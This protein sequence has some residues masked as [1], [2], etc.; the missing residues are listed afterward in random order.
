VETFQGKQQ[1]ALGHYTAAMVRKPT[2]CDFTQLTGLYFQGIDQAVADRLL[3]ASVNYDRTS[4]SCYQ[5]Y[6][7]YL[8]SRNQR[9]RALA[10]LEQ[11]MALEAN[12]MTDYAA[13]AGIMKLSHDEFLRILPKRVGPYLGY[14]SLLEKR[15]DVEAAEVIYRKA[16]DL[17]DQEPVPFA[18]YYQ[19]LYTL[20]MKQKRY[21]EAL[22]LLNRAVK[23]IP[24]DQGL[25]LKLA[26]LYRLLGITYR[27]QEEEALAR[28]LKR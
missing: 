23:Q 7:T 14:A 21:D 16:L 3:D 8:M 12:R 22:E 27:A 9:D 2:A 19:G 18:R 20:L 11:A 4:P 15:G 28:T 1:E 24:A 10:A 25:H 5:R 13:I 26:N 17:I 6:A